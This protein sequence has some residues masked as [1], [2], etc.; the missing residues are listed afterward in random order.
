MCSDSRSSADP[1]DLTAGMG[2][3]DQNHPYPSAR[4][5]YCNRMIDQVLQDQPQLQAY[6]NHFSSQIESGLNDILSANS[7]MM[8]TIQG[9]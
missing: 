6:F 9:L 2:Q 3:Y 5:A 8:Q 4:L 1:A 7:S